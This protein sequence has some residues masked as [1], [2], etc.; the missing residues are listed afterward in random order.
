[1]IRPMVAAL[2]QPYRGNA[3]NRPRGVPIPPEH[4]SL[5][6]AGQLLKRWHYVSFWSE[7]LSFCAARASVGPLQQE[8]WGIWDRAAQQFRQGSHLFSQRVQIEP[9]RVRVDDGDAEINVAFEPCT[10]SQSPGFRF[11]PFQ[12]GWHFRHLRLGNAQ[13]TLL[14]GRPRRFDPV[15]RNNYRAAPHL[16][17]LKQPDRRTTLPARAEDKFALP[18]R[19]LIALIKH[20][21]GRFV[22][23]PAQSAQWNRGC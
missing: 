10:S 23:D 19:G 2:N 13:G 12:D 8:Y 15:V 18:H 22:P 14:P 3:D 17:H 9:N 7:H 16:H 11:I 1:M 5:F 4:L 20:G 6:R 21:L